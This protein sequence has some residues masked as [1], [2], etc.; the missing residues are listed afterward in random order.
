MG[1]NSLDGYFKS[2]VLV[3]AESLSPEGIIN[4][5]SKEGILLYD[6]VRI[7]HTTII[8]KM[9]HTQYRILKKT[10]YNTNTKIK[11]LKKIGIHFTYKSLD[12]RKFFILGSIIFAG[13]IIFFSS[14]IWKVDITGN[15]N[16]STEVINETLKKAGLRVGTLKYSANLRKVEETVIR[17]IK[18]VSVIKINFNGTQANVEI[19][20]R[21]MPPK[22]LDRAIP[23]NIVAAKEGVITKIFSYKGFPLVKI[24]DFVKP[25]QI[26]ISGLLSDTEN[27]FNKPIHAMGSVLAKTW[28]ESI[29]VVNFNYKYETRT[30]KFK[31]KIYYEFDKHRLYLK[32]NNIT[33][34]KYDKIENKNIIKLIGFSTPVLKVT[35]YYYEKID[36]YKLLSFNEAANLGIQEGTNS[37]KGQIPINA[38][39]IDIKNYKNRDKKSVKVRVLY[40][41]EENIGSE[42]EIK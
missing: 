15:K 25:N 5:C 2:Y 8:F 11:I 42:K 29:R 1:K 17:N 41:L 32:N 14:I 4:K 24:G 33:F 22:I 23:T 19:V 26:L 27:E 35:E 18:E 37:I 21:T 16:I 7:N 20:E 34:K 13:L 12:R 10:V 9:K 36:T 38:K 6:I 31:T 28:Y 39:I 40:I 30:G 3:K